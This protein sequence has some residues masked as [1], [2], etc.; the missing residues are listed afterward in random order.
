[1]PNISSETYSSTENSDKVFTV[2]G[3]T[4]EYGVPPHIVSALFRYLNSRISPGGF[5]TAVLLNDLFSAIGC[6]DKQ[7]LVGLPG[8]CRFIYCSV[9]GRAHGSPEKVS[10]WL[11]VLDN[12]QP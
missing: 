6:A 3:V 11:K 1:M 5:L 7:S 10:A 12:E 4:R 9:D 2:E 8:L